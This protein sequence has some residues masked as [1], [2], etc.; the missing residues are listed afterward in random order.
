M[1]LTDENRIDSLSDDESDSTF[2][3]EN[4]HCKQLLTLDLP[5]ENDPQT[6]RST[7]SSQ[8]TKMASLNPNLNEH[9]I[10]TAPVATTSSGISNNNRNLGQNNNVRIGSSQAIGSAAQS[11]TTGSNSGEEFYLGLYGW[12]KKC[13]YFLILSL[14]IL[15]VV[16]LALTLW[17]LKVMEFTTDGMGQLK[18]V[19]GGLQLSGQAL[20]LDVLRASSIRSRHGQPITIESSKNFSINTRDYEGR[21]DNRLFLG[22]DKLEIL[23]H[24]FKVIDTH[25]AMLFSVN[26]NEV[27]IGANALNVE[28]EG[29]AV[30]RES[31]QT[32]LIRAEPG[33]ELKLES[34]TRSL[35][36]NAGKDIFIKSGA[37]NIDASCL[38]DIRIQSEGSIRLDSASILM[39]NLKIVQPAGTSSSSSAL[40]S[41]YD[42]H[43]QLGQQQQ[44]QPPHHHHKIYQLCACSNG[45]LFL[46]MS[47]SI[48]AG[49]ESTVCR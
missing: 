18:I 49:D 9:N 28:G 34:P 2:T 32:P 16:N 35:L 44:Q 7:G 39:P 42:H 1:S 23:S 45:K 6:S 21:L 14:A 46:A 5:N 3:S 36:I 47:H 17:I 19:P 41:T 20:F 4:A 29:G 25:G 12:R 11:R 24:H 37:G 30:F 33:K 13:L 27:S 22:H 48:C 8:S 10:T 26:K 38:N 40:P 31:I 15:I 43:H